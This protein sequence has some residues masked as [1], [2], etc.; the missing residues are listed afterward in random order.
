MP[1]GTELWTQAV[2]LFEMAL[3]QLAETAVPEGGEAQVDNSLV[4]PVG[5]APDEAGGFRPVD[6]LDRAVVPEQEGLGDLP[7]GR[8]FPARVPPDREQQLVLRRREADGYRLCLAP[9]QEAAQAGPE[10]EQTCVVL[11][12]KIEGHIYIVSR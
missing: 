12:G 1:H 10:L 4:A 9:A 5:M 6:Q 7:D 11:V 2:E 3:A 8:T